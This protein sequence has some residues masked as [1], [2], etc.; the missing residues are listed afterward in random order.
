[1]QKDRRTNLPKIWLYK[2]KATGDGKG[3]ATVT[4]DDQNAAESAIKWF[5]GKN[6]KGYNIK[7][8]IAQRTNRRPMDGGGRGGPGRG[9]WGRGGGGERGGGRGGFGGDRGGYGSDMGGRGGG[10]GGGGADRG[11][12]Q[13]R[14][15]DWICT[16]CSN[17]NF[18]WRNECNRCKEAKAGGGGGGGG[19]G[20]RGGGG[21]YGGDRGGDRGGYGGGRG[22]R[23]GGRGGGGG[24][25]GDR[26]SGPMRGG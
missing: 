8:S 16:S 21:G 15:G 13:E 1:M 7:V 17:K 6:F 25:G 20:G 22:G 26:D 18:A 23:G 9:S 4:Y 10:G 24:Y 3:E 12:L 2:D 5:D 14:E 11:N 19:G